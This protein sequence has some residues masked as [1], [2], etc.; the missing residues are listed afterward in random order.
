[1]EESRAIKQK[2]VLLVQNTMKWL[3]K[4]IDPAFTPMQLKK[5]FL[6]DVSVEMKNSESYTYEDIFDAFKSNHCWSWFSFDTLKSI[7][8]L[9]SNF[10]MTVEFTNYEKAFNEYCSQRKLYECPTCFSPILHKLNRPVLIEF[11]EDIDDIT[12]FDLK[13]KLERKLARIIGVKERDFVLLTYK[14]GS[15]V[16]VYSLPR[17]V[18]DKVFPL[19]PEQKEML[20]KIGV[21][22]C[23][24]YSEPTNQVR[25]M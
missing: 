19:S 12:L 18:A 24:L 17:S 15:T 22:K 4:Q 25:C 13:K 9:M 7:I 21:S 14:D 6:N 16:L 10:E 11:P 1:M 20:A 8:E 3:T 2:F 23:Y 5:L